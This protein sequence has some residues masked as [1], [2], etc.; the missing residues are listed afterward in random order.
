MDLAFHGNIVCAGGVHR[1]GYL[2]IEGGKVVYVGIERP[3]TANKAD[4]SG[5][6]IFP[7]AIDAQ[8]DSRSQKGVKGSNFQQRPQPP[9]EFPLSSM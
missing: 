6:L 5:K 4:H 9:A 2:G 8:V 7:G 1:N 3:D